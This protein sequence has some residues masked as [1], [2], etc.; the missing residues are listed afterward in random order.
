MGLRKSIFELIIDF[1]VIVK[2]YVV[3][4]VVCMFDGYKVELY[5]VEV[6]GEVWIKG[7]NF[8]GEIWI[9]GVECLIFSER[10]IVYWVYLYE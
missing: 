7:V 4:E 2:G 8:L 3:D 5:M 10:V 9:I 1:L 6:G